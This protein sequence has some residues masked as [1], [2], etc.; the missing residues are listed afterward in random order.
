MK[1]A[2]ETVEAVV[3]GGASRLGAGADVTRV[4]L[5][6]PS[7]VRTIFIPLWRV[8]GCPPSADKTITVVPKG[9]VEDRTAGAERGPAGG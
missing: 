9:A 7:G 3:E 4:P 8:G 6:R 2:V 5:G 1:L